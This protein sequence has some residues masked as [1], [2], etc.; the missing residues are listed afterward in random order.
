M[1]SVPAD[2]DGWRAAARAFAEE[3]VAPLAEEIDRLDRMPE[4]LLR[5]LVESGFLGL[6]TPPAWG[7]V[8]GDDRAIAGVLEELARASATVAVRVAVH[9]SVAAAPIL[10][11]GTDAQRERFLRPLATGRRFGAFAL[12]EPDVGSDTAR[13]RTRYVAT[14]GGY[15]LTGR[16]MFI[17][18]AVPDATVLV[19]ATRDPALGHRGIA[20]FVVPADAPGFSIA[21]PLDKLGL[22]GSETTEIVLEDVAVDAASRLGAE[23]EGLRI[24]LGSLAGGRI[25]I[26]AC[27]LG[28]AEAAFEELRRAVLAADRDGSRID[29]ARSFAELESARALVDRAIAQRES[30]APYVRAASVAKLVA[31][32]AAVRIAGRGVDAAGPLGVRSGA[33]AERLLRDARVFPIVEGTTEIQEMIL[34]RELLADP[35]GRH[36]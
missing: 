28:V 31:S 1:G 35:D 3:R 30:G 7:G 18:N 16:K 26:A 27:A 22:K 11:F 33:A 6:G 5:A 23:G 4:P 15:R 25:G 14:D 12:T 24:A 32:Q 2:A 20:A 34:A 13:L 19:F 21:P 36:P 9:L 10:R 17:S 29:L 8:G